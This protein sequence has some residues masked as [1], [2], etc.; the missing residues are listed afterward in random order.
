MG[1][2]FAEYVTSGEEISRKVIRQLNRALQPYYFA[3]VNWNN[4]NVRQCPKE[5]ATVFNG[6]RIL[7]Y[8]FT[9]EDQKNLIGKSIE[10]CVTDFNE[11]NYQL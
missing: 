9:K 3:N 4:L 11:K 5:N 2:G 7:V 10:L 1:K 8:G 6:D